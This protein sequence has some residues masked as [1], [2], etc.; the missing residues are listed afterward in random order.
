MVHSLPLFVSHSFG[1]HLYF[2]KRME[3]TL[4]DFAGADGYPMEMELPSI[5]LQMLSIEY[6]ITHVINKMIWMQQF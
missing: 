4:V 2:L 3:E 5:T 6:A 1:L